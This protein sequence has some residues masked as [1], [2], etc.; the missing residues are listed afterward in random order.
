MR[1][2]MSM[3]LKNVW[4]GEFT[5]TFRTCYRKYCTSETTQVVHPYRNMHPWKSENE[6]TN[7]LLKNVIYNKDGIIAIKKPY[8]IPIHNMK[9]N[10]KTQRQ[11]LA[12]HKIVGAV[13]YVIEDSLPYL[14][15]ELDVPILIP[16][17][18]AEKY[19]SGVYIF[20]IND[21][22][23]QQ[24]ELA[25]RRTVGKYRKYWIVTTRVPNDIKGKHHLGMIL[26][27][28]V[29]GEKKPIILDK[30]SNNAVKRDEVKILNVDYKVISNSTHNLSSL[31]EIISSTRKWHAIRLFASTML[32][33]PILGDNIHGSRI[34]E[35]MGTWLRVDPFSDSCWDPPK[36]NRQL[37]DL[38]DVKPSQQEIIP[39]HVHL[40]SVHF[41]YGKEKKDII[42]EASLTE[43]FDW[44]CKQLK[45][46]M[47]NE[48]KND[49]AANQEELACV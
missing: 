44:T 41:I 38:L 25:T 18:G 23:C 16:C 21:K 48:E 36:L 33:A 7:H 34:Q 9:P 15:K 1:S 45:F 12:T 24:L 49:V 37:L 29:L 3:V 2:A 13:D 31:I 8:G 30:W 42:I 19:M 6:F 27:T 47:P 4:I 5:A 40:K 17:L 14:A 10:I 11:L 28:S 39:T 26:K 43:S 32:Y 22:V 35:F 20:G 46:K